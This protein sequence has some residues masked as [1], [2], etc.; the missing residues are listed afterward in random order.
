MLAVIITAADLEPDDRRLNPP[1]E[2]FT[3]R[4]HMLEL[5]RA[6]DVVLYERRTSLID[7]GRADTVWHKAPVTSWLIVKSREREPGT[8]IA[9]HLISEVV[10][11]C[12]VLSMRSALADLGI[13]VR[14]DG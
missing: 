6:C 2:A 14:E 8:I 7:P 13:R 1:I 12:D 11:G 10:A 3:R 5:V 4:P 9:F